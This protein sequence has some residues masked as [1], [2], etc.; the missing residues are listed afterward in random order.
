VMEKSLQTTGF[1]VFTGPSQA[2]FGDGTG[3]EI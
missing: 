3:A 2:W 1:A